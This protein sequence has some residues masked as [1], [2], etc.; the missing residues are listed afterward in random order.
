MNPQ[1]MRPQERSID[2]GIEHVVV[3]AEDIFVDEPDVPTLRDVSPP[4]SPKRRK[5]PK[6]TTLLSGL[7]TVAS[8]ALVALVARRR[9]GHRR[10]RRGR[11]ARLGFRE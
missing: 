11:V 10:S 9:A 7:V 3:L 8:L 1:E 5:V 2:E 6:K 4:V